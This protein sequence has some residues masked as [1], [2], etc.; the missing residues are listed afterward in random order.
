MGLMESGC[1]RRDFGRDVQPAIPNRPR[2]WSLVE[3][4]FGAISMYEAES[5][6]H[7]S[8]L[9]WALVLISLLA[10]LEFSSSGGES[11]SSHRT[12]SITR[13][14]SE[15]TPPTWRKR[16]TQRVWR[17]P[18]WERRNDTRPVPCD[19]DGMFSRPT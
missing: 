6:Q 16:T 11:V 2:C 17:E 19:D 10:A 14:C 3:P 8:R 1:T 5:T 7:Q 15:E 9:F 13:R 18:V 12:A 4:T